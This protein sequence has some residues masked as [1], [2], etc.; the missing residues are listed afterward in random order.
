MNYYRRRN[1][2]Q[3]FIL[4]GGLTLLLVLLGWSFAGLYGIVW[5]FLMGAIPFFIT[6]R[7]FPHLTLKMYGARPL[8]RDEAPVLHDVVAVLSQRASLPAPPAVCYIPANTVLIFSVGKGSNAAVAIS[9]GIF[10]LF[11]LRELVAVLGHEIAHIRRGDTLVM[12]FADVV[13]RISH[14]LSFFGM[15]L[16]TVNLPLLLLGSTPVPWVPIILMITAPTVSALLQLALSR[17]REFEADILGAEVSGDPEALAT[18]LDKL[19]AF[20]LEVQKRTILPARGAEP[21]FLRTHPATALR[22]ERLRDIARQ[23]HPPAQEDEEVLRHLGIPP[24]RRTG[25][26]WN[27]R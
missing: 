8:S 9:A 4:I 23:A 3:S 25:R 16:L 19:E 14:F 10:H 17:S 1:L 18:A 26:W 12:A 20:R 24:G 21:S 2:I 5:A 15:I 22:I 7:L 27:R 11:T 13:T 6:V